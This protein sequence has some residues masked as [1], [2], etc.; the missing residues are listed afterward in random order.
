QLQYSSGKTW[1]G[2]EKLWVNAIR[3]IN[4]EVRRGETLG[5][6]G[7][8][9]SGKS[10]LGRAILGLNKP[11]SGSISY[12]GVEL[13]TMNK[14]SLLEFR[15]NI[16]IVFQDPYSSL[17]PRLTIGPA[18]AEP[19]Q[20]HGSLNRLERIARVMDILQKVDLMPEHFNRYPHAFSGGQRQRVVIARALVLNPGLVVFDESVSALDVSIQA[21]ILNL[22]NDLKERLGFTAVFISHDLSVIRYLCDRVL[23]MEKGCIIESGNVESVYLNPQTAYTRSLIESIP[24]TKL[25]IK[26]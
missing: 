5:L 26:D 15:R 8:S 3:D 7:E 4:F 25:Q 14:A 12:N 1:L 21:Q 9:G 23:V 19:L 6:V 20:V 2:R 11:T 17:N 16:Q 10:T 24:G 18:I 13:L 22:I